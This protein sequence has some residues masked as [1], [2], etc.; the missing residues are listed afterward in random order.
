MEVE[1]A[2]EQ[3][4]NYDQMIRSLYL[5]CML[6]VG[7]INSLKLTVKMWILC[8]IFTRKETSLYL[9]G[10][11]NVLIWASSFCTVVFEASFF[12]GVTLHA[13]SIKLVN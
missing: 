3:E 11:R 7:Q 4:N 13:V 9:Q 8:F 12:V 10:T 1:S 5:K 6:Y 2:R